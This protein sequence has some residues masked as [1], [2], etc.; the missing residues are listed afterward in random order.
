MKI[1]YVIPYFAPKHGGDVNVCY[2]LIKQLVKRGHE[3]TI[4]T[5]D[6]EFDDE[7][8][9]SIVGAHVNTFKC[10]VNL[11]SFLYSP[12]M[13]KWLRNN[14]K[15]FNIVHLHTYRSY[16]NNVIHQYTKKYKIPYVV[17]AHGSLPIM[18][19]KQKL[20][21][22]YDRLWG[23]KI[24]TNASRVLALNSTEAD[25]Y[26]EMGVNGNNIVMIPNGIDQCKFENLPTKGQFKKRYGT[27]WGK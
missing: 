8:A 4:I 19:Q 21:K 12:K 25:Q 27:Y 22:I 2:N 24:L 18:I 15:D 16:Q 6:F 14:I 17:Q 9:K 7:Y 1:L 10:I 23:H 26:R 11:N 3:V 13:K 20:K 5:T